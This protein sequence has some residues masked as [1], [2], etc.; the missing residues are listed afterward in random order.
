MDRVPDRAGKTVLVTGATDGIGRETARQL[1]RS[2]FRVLVHGRSGQRV[3][4]AVQYVADAAAQEPPQGFVADLSSLEQVRRLALE[5]LEAAPRLDVLINNA[6]IFSPTSELSHDGYELTL[7]VNHLAPFLLTNLLLDRLVASAPSRVVNVASG[8]HYS[9]RLDFAR[10]GAGDSE[11]RRRRY[12]PHEAYAQ[13]KLCNVLFT[14]ALADRLR[15]TG[16]T[17]NCLH[18]GVV[19]TKLLRAGFGGGRGQH[20][21]EGARTSVYLASAPEV[22]EVSGRFF[23][24]REPRQKL[25]PELRHRD[26]GPSLGGQRPPGRPERTLI[27]AFF[28]VETRRSFQ[29]PSSASFVTR[30]VPHQNRP[31]AT[32]VP[33][34][35]RA[36]TLARLT[37]PPQ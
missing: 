14:Y 33:I 26:A 2:G 5:V 34:R 7:A 1:A 32:A 6:G 35:N 19:A 36:R 31:T 21:L 18:P 28:R 22:A 15:G 27:Q 24:E 9:A 12:D 3:A 30:D 25:A 8:T 29:R 4:A 17:A 11:G 16:V 20:P 13:S 37:L 10:L 23:V